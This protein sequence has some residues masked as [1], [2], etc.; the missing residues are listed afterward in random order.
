MLITALTACDLL[1]SDVDGVRLIGDLK[2]RVDSNW[3][4]YRFDEIIQR[5][6]GL[7]MCRHLDLMEFRKRN[8]DALRT[9]VKRA[10]LA[11]RARAAELAVEARLLGEVASTLSMTA[12]EINEKLAFRSPEGLVMSLLL[13]QKIPPNTETLP[14]LLERV[15]RGFVQTDPISPSGSLDTPSAKGS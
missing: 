1:S 12:S 14:S 2:E 11:E 6:A 15:A 4:P 13:L 10:P 3:E 5:S 7:L 8:L 9:A